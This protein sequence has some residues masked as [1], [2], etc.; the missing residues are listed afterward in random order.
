MAFCDTDKT[1]ALRIVDVYKSF[2]NNRVLRGV[3]FEI[4]RGDVLAL[5]GGNGAGKSTL[6]KIIMGIYSADRGDIYVENEN[7]SK[8]TPAEAMKRGV[9][10]VPQEPL[11]F[12]HM[13]VFENI[14]IGNQRDKVVLRNNL[15]DYLNELEWNL[16]LDRR[17]E[18]L[19]IA[20]QQ[21]V[22]I[23]RGLLREAKLIIFDEPTSALTYEEVKSFFKAVRKLQKKQITIIYI[24]H[25]L[26]EI[27]E[28][29]SH[30]AI[31]RD[32]Q[33][34]AKGII[35]DFTKKKL[36]DAMLPTDGENSEFT[37]NKNNLEYAKLDPILI[38]ENFSGYGFRDVSFRLYPGEILGLAGVVGAG[39]TEL[40][41]TLFGMEH[42]LKG[43]V[44][45]DGKD[46]TNL[47]TK[48]V[49]AAGLN[50]V[51]ED[52]FKHGIFKS[53]SIESNYS[54]TSLEQSKK[55]FLKRKQLLEDAQ[56]AIKKYRVVSTGSEQTIGSLSGGNQQKL[57]LAKCF[58]TNP[59]VV[60][61][62]EPT[63][64]IDAA[65]RGDLYRL[66]VQMK[67]Q[68]ASIL[69]ISSDI[70]EV[71]EL[72]DRVAVMHGGYIKQI[73]DK[74]EINQESITSSAFGLAENK[75]V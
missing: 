57:V 63:R 1:S 53:L 6:M 75:H 34:T 20:E 29:A 35:G 21:L 9:Y 37:R 49:I 67:E 30:I 62:D 2:S 11:L 23:L 58:S 60:I 27:F 36:I 32:G 59:K 44:Y 74:D 51:P 45:L 28:I 69:L 22:E 54:S 48:E 38:V 17:A 39:R 68:G 64:G 71:I 5:I 65:A 46:I 7:F 47:S 14:V 3:S 72:S 33:I 50:Y 31:M 4:C 41:T 73:F 55:V 13:T 52:R 61:L 56:E 8:P 19:S 66:I 40:A 16:D 26:N 70:E 15:V 24:S 25:R 10:L 18:T 12:P 42:S 43:R